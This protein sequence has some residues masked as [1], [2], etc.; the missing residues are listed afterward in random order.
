MEQRVRKAQGDAA[1]FTAIFEEYNKAKSITKT[2][3]YLET[4]LEILPGM[5]KYI[6]QSDQ[7]G[8]IVNLLNLN[9]G[10]GE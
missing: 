9:K 4:M 1:R 2:R 7:N 8:G 5:E 10:G 6:I 3:M